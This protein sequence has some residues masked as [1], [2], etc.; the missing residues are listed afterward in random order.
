[1]TYELFFKGLIIGFS[2]AAP[3]GPIGI[4]CIRRSLTIGKWSGICT[5]LGA[6]AAD[7]IYGII[8]VLGLTAVSDILISYDWW[9]KMIGASFLLYLGCK[10]FF[11]THISKKTIS[12][13]HHSLL[14]DFSST[15]LL[16]LTNPITI[17]SFAAIYAG[18][19][20]GDVHASPLSSIAM[21]IGVSLGSTLWWIF[22]V[23]G[24]S[25]F[26]TKL[27]TTH[28]KWIDWISGCVLIGFAIIILYSI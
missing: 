8:A 24:I 12:S 10:S 13:S 1:M 5:G 25:V 17:L 2:I 3:V 18:M 15:L 14:Q 23:C 20:L 7:T 4:L 6:A 11:T 26:K 27:T 9:M 28:M 19:G 22:L 21:V 16:T